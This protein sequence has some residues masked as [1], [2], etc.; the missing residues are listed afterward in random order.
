MRG[1]EDLR[2]SDDPFPDDDNP[3]PSPEEI[4]EQ[5]RKR[6]EML[7]SVAPSPTAGAVAEQKESKFNKKNIEFGNLLGEGS[8][9]KVFQ[10]RLK[11]TNEEFAV[12][13]MDKKHILRYKKEQSVMNEK[14]VL[15]MLNHPNLMKMHAAYQ[16]SIALC[17]SLQCTSLLIVFLF[18]FRAGFVPRRRTV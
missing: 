15:S 11:A 17:K 10:V 14:T 18:R 13:M 9:A 1:S 8:Y 12:K 3:G 2:E 16:D 7:N 5:E 4:A 6:A